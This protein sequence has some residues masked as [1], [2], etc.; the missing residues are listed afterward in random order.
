MDSHGGRWRLDPGDPRQ[1]QSL[2]PTAWPAA[3]RPDLS[4]AR[5]VAAVGKWAGGATAKSLAP[6]GHLPTAPT[7]LN[8]TRSGVVT[9]PCT[10]PPSPQAKR[11][12]ETKK[13]V[14]HLT[15][16]P[17]GAER[18]RAY[19]AAASPNA[20][21]LGRALLRRCCSLPRVAASVPGDARWPRSCPR[22]RQWSSTW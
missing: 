1:T 8:V 11:T 9:A 12:S 20:I 15:S 5:G 7:P 21:A 14:A 16:P 19:H 17:P 6:P 2:G 3:F 22:G 10:T 18:N 4:P 13:T